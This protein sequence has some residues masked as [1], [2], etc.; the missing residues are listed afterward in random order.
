MFHHAVDERGQIHCYWLGV[1][2]SGPKVGGSQRETADERALARGK[3]TPT[4]IG[5]RAMGTRF[6]VLMTTQVPLRA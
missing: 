3:A 4:V 6:N 2:S 1:E 5:T